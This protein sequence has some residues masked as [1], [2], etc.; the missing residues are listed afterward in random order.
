MKNG[1]LSR[2]ATL[3][4]LFASSTAVGICLS[5][6]VFAQAAADAD[7]DAVKQSDAVGEIV[8][9]ANRR[10]ENLQKV[11]IS[12]ASFTGEAIEDAGITETSDLGLITTG[13]I[14]SEAGGSELSGNVTIRG[15]S[16]NDFTGQIESPNAFYI[17][18]FYQPASSS[19]VQQLFDLKRVEVLKGPQGTLFGR[20]ATGGLVNVFTN[21]PTDVLSGYIEAGAGTHNNFRVS[22][23]VSGP[24]SDTTTGRLA[25]YRNSH[26]AYY[27]NITPTG[28]DLNS[29]DTLALRAK[30]WFEPNDKATIKLGGDYYRTKYKGTGGSYELPAAVDPETGLGYNLPKDTPFALAPSFVQT[31]GPF[32][33]SASV[34]GGYFREAYGLTA[35]VTYELG[36]VTLSSL[37]NYSAVK[38]N[39]LEDNDQ[40][41]VDVGTFGQDSDSKHFTQELRLAGDAGNLKWSAGTYYMYINGTYGNR[42]NFQA[43]DADLSTVYRIKTNSISGFG[44]ASLDVSDK[45]T[46]TIG[47]RV[48]RDTRD[49]VYNWS[50]LGSPVAGCAAFGG[51]GTIGEAARTTPGGLARKHS[52]TGW[53]GRFQLDYKAS[54]NTL[55][56]ASV[57]RGYKGFNFNAN[58]AGNVPVSG[59]VL[60]GEKL[61]AYEVGGKFALLDRKLRL[62]LAGYIYDYKDY[63]AFDQRGLNFTLFNAD[64][65]ISG[66][67]GDI[68]VSPGGG[69]TLNAGANYLFRANVFKVP[70]ADMLLT[71]RSAQTPDISGNISISKK[72]DTKAGEFDARGTMAFS[73]SYFSYLSNAPNTLLPSYQNFNFRLGFTPAH[74]QN[75][76]IGL[77][78]SNCSNNKKPNY[79]FDLAVAGYT[80]LNFADPRIF[81]AEV[82]I[83]Y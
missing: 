41:P 49:Y 74:A 50:C 9:T 34:P 8:V 62:N 37:S 77:Y 26:G 40:T 68:T 80:E 4:F 69:W 7:A 24:L 70:I 54:D 57:N 45:L 11:G 10:E 15:V 71:R 21:D 28:P 6:P 61:L 55:L 52:E 44:Q 53:T 58:F 65:K 48:V 51:P 17:D 19:A 14:V 64:A 36:D 33:T 78:C 76:N 63:H 22:G 72:F 29:D 67:E 23:A 25:V 47:A 66:L 79:A 27:K 13:L 81:G 82:K 60:R 56:Y 12:A 31:G 75:V 35:N 38:T 32:E 16:Q 1:P 42:F 83:S 46:A 20:N 30:L 18:E 43:A 3:K 59:L 39:Y 2:S 73:S 5:Q